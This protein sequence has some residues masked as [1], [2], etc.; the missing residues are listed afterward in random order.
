[1]DK[2]NLTIG[3][4]LMLAAFASLY[5]SQKLTPAPTAPMVPP[6]QPPVPT[7]PT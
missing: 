7:G 1:M 3:V 4:L 6:A 5:F 2:K